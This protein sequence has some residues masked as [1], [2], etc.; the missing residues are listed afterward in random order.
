MKKV[1]VLAG[2]GDDS[3]IAVLMKHDFP[4]NVR[5]IE[6]ILQHAFVLCKESAIQVAH[7][8]KEF[9]VDVGQSQVKSPLSLEELEKRVIQEAL[10]D[11]SNNRTAAAKQLGIDPSTLYRKMKRYGIK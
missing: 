7:L 4:G 11:N 6:N 1:L 5:E 3:V 2:H 10:L 8:P 9:V